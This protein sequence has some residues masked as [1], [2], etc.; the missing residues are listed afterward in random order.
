MRRATSRPA[1]MPKKTQVVLMGIL[2]P[3]PSMSNL[4]S[5]S[6]KP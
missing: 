4:N 2:A 1:S 5:K 6:T 3:M